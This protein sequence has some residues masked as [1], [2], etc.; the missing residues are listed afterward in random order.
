LQMICE[1][2]GRQVMA[3]HCGRIAET[4]HHSGGR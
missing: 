1:R 2:V 4:G 3:A